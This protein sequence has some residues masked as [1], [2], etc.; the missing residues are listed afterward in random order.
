MR[1]Y[2]LLCLCASLV[3]AC[4]PREPISLTDGLSTLIAEGEDDPSFWWLAENGERCITL[5]LGPNQIDPLG[6]LVRSW[7]IVAYLPGTPEHLSLMHG[8]VDTDSRDPIALSGSIL[9]V[10]ALPMGG[11]H[12][13]EVRSSGDLD[14]QLQGL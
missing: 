4:G 5:W 10:R 8:W 7:N 14:M 13:R 3:A 2:F 6:K 1:S 11:A 9:N 12:W